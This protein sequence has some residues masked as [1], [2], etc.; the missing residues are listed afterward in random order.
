MDMTQYLPIISADRLK[1]TLDEL[2][3]TQTELAAAAQRRWESYQNKAS[4][5]KQK[6]ELETAIKLT[7]AEAFM[8][9]TEG[10]GKEQRGIIGDNKIL[11]NNEDN[12]AA[13]RRMSSA[14]DRR[15][16]GS[17]LA[18]LN[19]IDVEYAHADT[20][21]Q[22]AIEVAAIIKARA[23]LQAKLLGIVGGSR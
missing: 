11:L 19:H 18:D 4:L 17:V 5:M 2:Q 20:A 1:E 10:E 23:A 22:E 7:E 15:Q 9:H 6:T 16:L 8:E 12:R 13:F 21:W 14:D 3:R